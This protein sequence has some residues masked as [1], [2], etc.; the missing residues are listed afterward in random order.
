MLLATW[1][2]LMVV[3][4]GP[5]AHMACAIIGDLFVAT[6]ADLLFLPAL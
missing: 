5:S 6:F 4:R 2:F 1:V 3:I